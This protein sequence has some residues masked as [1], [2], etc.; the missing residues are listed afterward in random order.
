MRNHQPKI[1]QAIE[2]CRT[3]L[4]IKMRSYHLLRFVEQPD[5][6]AVFYWSV[7]SCFRA[8]LDEAGARNGNITLNF[9]SVN[10]NHACCD[11]LLSLPS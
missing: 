7:H 5:S 3:T 1:F 4:G 2:H 8:Y 6:C 11:E 10:S 9:F